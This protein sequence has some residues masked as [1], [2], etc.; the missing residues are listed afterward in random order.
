MAIKFDQLPDIVLEAIFK[1]VKP[2]ELFNYRLLNKYIYKVVNYVIKQKLMS[3]DFRLSQKYSDHQERFIKEN[4]L[5]MKHIDI[6]NKNLEYINQCQNVTSMDYTASFAVTNE[7]M[8]IFDETTIKFPNL[9]RLFICSYRMAKLP[10]FFD[11]CLDQ[12]ETLIIGGDDISINATIQHRNLSN[13]RIFVFFS[14]HHLNLDGIDLLK[15]KFNRLKRLI[16]ATSGTLFTPA[17]FNPNINFNS[18]LELEI[19]GEFEELDISCLG[20]LQKLKRV[21]FIDQSGKYFG[22]NENYNTIKFIEEGNIACLGFLGSTYPIDN[23]FLKLS[24]LKE[25]FVKRLSI[26]VLKAIYLLP[27]IQKMDISEPDS[28]IL[29]TI[30]ISNDSIKCNFI[31]QIVVNRFDNT[32]QDFASFLSLF[33]NLESIKIYTFLPKNTNRQIRGLLKTS[34]S[35]L[36]NMTGPLMN[37]VKPFLRLLSP[38]DSF[39]DV[40][41]DFPQR[42]SISQ[43]KPTAPLLLI[44]PIYDKKAHKEIKKNTMINV[45]LRS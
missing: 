5:L 25:I 17:R 13:L 4:P 18:N 41:N 26:D 37:A 33:P 15:T 10:T 7:N 24:T 42:P 36:S 19:R 28:G 9:K 35:S 12:V 31:K 23:S 34:L 43:Y 39:S 44:A 1:L 20:N 40:S 3:S 32:L 30:D 11:N 27:N 45:Y 38:L 22:I 14:D 6:G 21:K 2:D 29:D 16:L 8:T